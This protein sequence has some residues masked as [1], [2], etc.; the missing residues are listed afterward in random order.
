M[1]HCRHPLAALPEKHGERPL[2]RREERVFGG[3]SLRA[4]GR[5]EGRKEQSD[6]KADA[7]REE[8]DRDGELAGFLV[9]ARE[10]RCEPK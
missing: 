2:R 8:R 1:I 9:L 3:A 10:K 7:R 5:E 4:Q 6:P